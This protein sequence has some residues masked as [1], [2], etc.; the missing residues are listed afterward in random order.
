MRLLSARRY[1]EEPPFGRPG[2]WEDGFSRQF[3]REPCVRFAGEAPP[4]RDSEVV[5]CRMEQSKPTSRKPF[6]AEPQPPP[7][8][9]LLKAAN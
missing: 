4:L 1:G 3:R 8:I 2:G 5:P 9:E 6:A 7:R